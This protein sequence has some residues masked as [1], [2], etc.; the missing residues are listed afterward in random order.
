LELSTANCICIR[1]YPQQ[2]GAEWQPGHPEAAGK[3]MWGK[4]KFPNT[5]DDASSFNA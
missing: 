5:A 4:G 2:C 1:I 3:G